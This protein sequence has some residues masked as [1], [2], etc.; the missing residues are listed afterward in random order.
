MHHLEFGTT[1]V[2][3]FMHHNG[4]DGR[5]L[6]LFVSEEQTCCENLVDI[7]IVFAPKPLSSYPSLSDDQ[8]VMNYI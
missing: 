7:L 6:F 3:C 8:F 2:I 5:F 1:A 4:P